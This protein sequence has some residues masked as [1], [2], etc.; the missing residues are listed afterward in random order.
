MRPSARDGAGRESAGTDS[1]WLCRPADFCRGGRTKVR[2]RDGPMPYDGTN[3]SRC[4]LVRVEERMRS[5]VKFRNAQWE[6]TRSGIVS[7]MGLAP[8]RF[9]I[10]SE[11]LLASATIGGRQLYDWP[12][13]LA[14]KRWVQLDLFFEAFRIAL[15]VHVGRFPGAV[16]HEILE[17]SFIEAIRISERRHPRTTPGHPKSRTG[18]VERHLG[19]AS[20]LH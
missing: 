14:Q 7:R 2:T 10:D 19:T 4:L 3:A 18:R 13:Y 1:A 15:D 5:S 8:G 17:A 12:L 6:V 16:D 11:L 9:Q 20:V